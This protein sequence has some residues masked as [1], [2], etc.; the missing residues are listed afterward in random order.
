MRV[1][2]PHPSRGPAN[3]TPVDFFRPATRTT[4]ATAY[5]YA[6]DTHQRTPIFLGMLA[7]YI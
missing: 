5:I 3:S 7:G 1:G 6:H 2:G 4:C